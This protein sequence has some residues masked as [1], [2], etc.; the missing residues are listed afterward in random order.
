M[1]TLY[2]VTGK[3]LN[4]GRSWQILSKRPIPVLSNS[5]VT[6]CSSL[7]VQYNSL[8]S[9]RAE[10]GSLYFILDSM[11]TLNILRFSSSS[12]FRLIRLKG[13]QFFHC[14]FFHSVWSFP[15]NIQVS[16]NFWFSSTIQCL[17]G[18]TF[19]CSSNSSWVS[20]IPCFCYAGKVR[21]LQ[22]CVPRQKKA[23]ILCVMAEWSIT[24]E[25][26]YEK[27]FF[28]FHVFF[29]E[30]SDLSLVLDEIQT[31]T[32]RKSFRHQTQGKIM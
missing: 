10:C 32:M 20:V 19:L 2:P 30:K 12:H 6:Q 3:I 14:F 31:L 18:F 13:I 27:S 4:N 28:H 8:A 9:Q 11:D 15:Q 17:P 22:K 21:G 7:A 1:L 25:W 5:T 24:M 26:L 29:K 16:F 23:E